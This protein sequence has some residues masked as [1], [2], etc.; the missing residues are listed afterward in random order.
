MR[1]GFAL[2]TAPWL[3][4]KKEMLILFL[5]WHLAQYSHGNSLGILSRGTHWSASYQQLQVHRN[6]NTIKQTLHYTY[7]VQAACH[8]STTCIDRILILP[9]SSAVLNSALYGSLDYCK[10]LMHTNK[11]G[12]SGAKGLHE[13]SPKFVDDV[14]WHSR[15]TIMQTAQGRNQRR[16]QQTSFSSMQPFTHAEE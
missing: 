1:P 8:T 5:F 9:R 13:Q 6:R 16:R 4:W 3:H 15:V 14:R 10:C 2:I 7:S 12:K 11:K